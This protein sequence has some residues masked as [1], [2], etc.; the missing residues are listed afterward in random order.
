MEKIKI[1]TLGEFKIIEHELG[2]GTMSRV[3]LGQWLKEP[4]TYI[5]VKEINIKQL[6]DSKEKQIGNEIMNML[7]L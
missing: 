6:E 4:K 2:R 7:K 3:L 5:A 1:K